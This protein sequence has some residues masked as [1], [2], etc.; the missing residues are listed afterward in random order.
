[1]LGAL[2]ASAELPIAKVN[3]WELSL[4]GRINTFVSYSTG[5]RQPKGTALWQ[6]IEDKP[7]A[8]GNISMTRIRSGFIQNV[9]GFTLKKKLTPDTLVTGRFAIW[10]GVSQARSRF[11]NP[12]L[13]AREVYFKVEGPWGGALAGRDLSLFG[14][15]AILLDYEIE[16]EYGLGH[17]CAIR[18]VQGGACGHA[19]HG[20][21]FPGYNAGIVYNTPELAGL[22]LSAGAFDPSVVTER[23]YERTPYPRVEGELA[24]KIPKYFHASVSGMWQRIGHN[25][26]LELNVDASG[27]SYGAGAFLGPLGLG[28]AGFAGQGLGIYAALENYPVFSDDKFVLRHQQGFLGMASLTLGDTKIAG[29]FGVTQISKTENDPPEPFTQL[30]FPRKQTGLSAGVYQSIMKTIVLAAEFFRAT[31]QFNQAI[32]TDSPAM[33]VIIT[34]RQTVN[35][36]NVGATLIF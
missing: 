21:L 1:M 18:M 12:A 2:S 3:N 19:G 26:N 9:L 35:F 10:V 34:P 14:R 27:V 20:I 7:D 33:D 8:D 22:Q 24:F 32:D 4:D 29:G 16:H 30:N 5:D 23:G 17:P 15:G 6:G 25:D 28:I 36:V 31:Y 11:D 13:D